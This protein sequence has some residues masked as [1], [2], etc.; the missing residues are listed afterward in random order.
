MVVVGGGPT[1]LETAGALHELYNFVLKNEYRQSRGVEA[2]VYLVEALDQLLLPYPKR[3]QQSALDQ[4]ESLGVK[5]ILSNPLAEISDKQVVLKNGQT[6]NTHT[7]IWAAGVKASPLSSMLGVELQKGGRV[8]ITP[9]LEVIGREHI[10]VVGDMAYLE[11]DQGQPYPMLIP[12]AKQQGILAAQNILRRAAN[13]QPQA[14]QYNDR[15]IMA[16]IGRRRAVAWIYNRIPL[17]GFIAWLAWLGLHLLWLLGF[18]N[19]LNVLVNW[20]WNYLTYDRSVRI[21]LKPDRK[22][23]SAQVE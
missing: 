23:N 6:I 12:V 11:D 13:E 15:G 18:R 19:R 17:T 2:K 22:T 21:I 3:L 7:L 16:T 9:E 20:V 4:L 10:Y 8:P 5:V 1:G 14:F